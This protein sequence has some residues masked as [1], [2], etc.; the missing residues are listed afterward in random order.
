LLRDVPRAIIGAPDAG[1]ER[2]RR[3]RPPASAGNLQAPAPTPARA[4]GCICSE[5]AANRSVFN[6]RCTG[7]PAPGDRRRP[8]DA[9]LRCFEIFSDPNLSNHLILCHFPSETA[10]NNSAKTAE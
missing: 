10:G 6:T 7:T 9:A 8:V 2:E 1:G 3:I 4:F 5:F